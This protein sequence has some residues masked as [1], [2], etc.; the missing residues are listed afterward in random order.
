MTPECAKHE[1]LQILSL[2]CICCYCLFNIRF[3]LFE[4]SNSE[5]SLFFLLYFFISSEVRVEGL[6]TLDY[7]DNLLQSRRFTEQADALTF[8]DEV[9]FSLFCMGAHTRTHFSS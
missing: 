2:L 8:D 1:V 5:D 6:E 3:F 4:T 9:S 7:L